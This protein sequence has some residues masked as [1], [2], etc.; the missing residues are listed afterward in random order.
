MTGCTSASASE[1]CSAPWR[2]ARGLRARTWP[3]SKI[4]VPLFAA[5]TLNTVGQYR[6]ILSRQ[7]GALKSSLW[8]MPGGKEPN[9]RPKTI[10]REIADPAQTGQTG[11]GGPRV[12]SR[13]GLF[14]AAHATTRGL[15]IAP[16]S[17]IPGGGVAPPRRRRRSVRM[18]LRCAGRGQA[19]RDCDGLRSLVAI[20]C[21][22][23][24]CRG[25][26]SRAAPSPRHTP[27]RSRPR[28]G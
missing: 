1:W 8:A 13:D 22:V 20:V 15:A 11:A 12:R 23:R 3:Q 25:R 4:R 27:T 28:C 9:I 26:A 5:R 2:P 16:S 19:I 24:C 7:V 21:L 14:F 18:R 6:V 17:K 10:R